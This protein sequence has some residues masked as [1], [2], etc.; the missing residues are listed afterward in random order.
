MSK[1]TFADLFAEETSGPEHRGRR[2]RQL[3]VGDDVEGV[4]VHVG[5]DEIFVELD[6]K[7][8]AWLDR[9]A[10][11]EPKVG[12]KVSGRVIAVD[13]SS[14]QIKIGTTLDSASSLEELTVAMDRAMAIEGKIVGTNKGGVEV[15]LSGS[16]RRA[17]CPFSQLDAR[18]V[19]DAEA[20]VGQTFSFLVTKVEGRDVV[21][22]RRQL[23]EREAERVRA[24]LVE[25]LTVDAII[26]GRVTQ[27]RD[28]GAFVDL[29][30]VEGL[31]PSRELSHDRVQ[32]PED[33]VQV[34][35][36]VD[37]KVLRIET[38][39]NNKTRITLSL[40]ALAGD[41]WDGIRA[42]APIGRVVAGQVTRLADFGAFVRLAP[43]IEGL[44]H[45]SELGARVG[46]P[47]EV[48]EVGKQVLV[49]IRDVDRSR[50]RVSL[51]LAGSSAQPGEEVRDLKPVRGAVVTATVEKHERFGVFAQIAGTQG[52]AGLGLVPQKE[53]GLTRGVDVRKALPVGEEIRAKVIDATEGR[54]RLSIRAALEDAER[55]VY[56][57][58]RHEQAK[59]ASMGTLGDLLKKKLEE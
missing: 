27:V 12:A 13:E 16:K 24:S 17:F 38:E 42:A 49:G 32:R 43:G 15:E 18:Y 36:V 31:I 50:R 40:K 6:A 48:L 5:R 33:V 35:D 37:V 52:R 10:I 9:A 54:I 44:L 28:F 51:A 22:S 11:A 14:D 4:I 8:Q 30:G 55:A 46:H 34:G 2:A 21:L 20:F 19:E 53:L 56:D 59:N 1:E 41:P 45:R 23:L 39:D 29:G 57:T 47:S 58:Y 25:T 7:Q 3:R 26:Q